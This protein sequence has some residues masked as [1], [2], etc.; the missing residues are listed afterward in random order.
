MLDVR[1]GDPGWNAGSAAAEGNSCPG[2]D[3]CAERS[4]AAGWPVHAG[5]AAKRHSASSCAAIDTA[6]SSEGDATF[7]SA[8]YSIVDTARDTGGSTDVSNAA[9]SCAP[10]GGNTSSGQ[11]DT[12]CSVAGD[13]NASSSA[14]HSDPVVASE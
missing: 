6:R 3:T 13:R 2:D 12:A 9:N 8:G 1:R 5:R 10:G 4:Q 7:G 14:T 11:P